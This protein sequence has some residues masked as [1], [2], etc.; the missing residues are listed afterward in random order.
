[1]INVLIA[2][3]LI[4]IDLAAILFIY[5]FHT[6]DKY[7]SFIQVKENGIIPQHGSSESA[8][9]DLYACIN[10]PAVIAPGQTVMIKTGVSITPPAG[11]FGAIF[12]R[13][14]LAT[15][16][17]LR[18]SNCVGV[19]DF[20]YTGEYI[21]ALHNDSSETQTVNPNDRIAQLVFLPYISVEFHEV[22]ELDE[23]K[24]GTGGFGHTGS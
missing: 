23:T 3:N 8:G 13:S 7:H 11:Y 20:D 21:V 22:E 2:I 10:E 15:K 17:G 16:K 12:A 24:R 5:Y 19:C 1:M 14:G 4:M 9:Y 18:P 6:E